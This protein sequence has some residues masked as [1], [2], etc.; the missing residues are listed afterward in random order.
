MPVATPRRFSGRSRHG[1]RASACYILPIF[2]LIGAGRWREIYIL[3][4]FRTFGYGGA[5]RIARVMN[6]A[7]VAVDSKCIYIGGREMAGTSAD[8]IEWTESFFFGVSLA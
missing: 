3:W 4:R 8:G 6:A 5:R 2:F 1:R 7:D